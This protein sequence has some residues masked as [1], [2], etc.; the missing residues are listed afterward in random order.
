MRQPIIKRKKL[1]FMG[2]VSELESLKSKFGEHC[3]I[4]VGIDYWNHG[5]T[6][7]TELIFKVAYIINSTI[8]FQDS[9]NCP[10]DLI[11]KV[12]LHLEKKNVPTSDIKDVMI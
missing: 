3:S 2:L 12:E 9:S 4:C 7:N 1:S 8:C 11:S 5:H 10:N 6:D